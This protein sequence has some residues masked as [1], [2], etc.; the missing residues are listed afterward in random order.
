MLMFS[1]TARLF[2][3]GKGHELG[4][5]YTV[6]LRMCF[7]L[8]APVLWWVCMNG[9]ALVEAI[10]ARGEFTV[11]M[12]K[13]VAATLIALAPSVL[14][15]GVGQLLANAFYALGRV[16]VPALVMPLGMV[17]F[18]AA[19]VPLSRALGTEGIAL[20]TTIASVMVFGILLVCLSKAIEEL[21]LGRVALHLLAY[22]AWGGAT[23]GGVT[24]VLREFA[25]APLAVAMVSL[26]VGTILYLGALALVRDRTFATLSGY[27]WQYI[28]RER[29]HATSS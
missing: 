2:A 28:A 18:V 3:D 22:I 12:A 23:M 17:L 26:P 27:A 9:Y 11:P 21:P 25:L 6:G 20:S 1:R 10:F 19:T 29:R 7:L 24:A 14:F 8:L 15:G 4:R 16:A 5:L 13:L